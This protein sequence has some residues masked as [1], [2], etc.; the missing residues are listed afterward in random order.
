M[1]GTRISRLKTLLEADPTD[2]FTQYALGLEYAGIGEVETAIRLLE[3]LRQQ[4]PAYVPAYH[5]LGILYER[6]G[7]PD[8]ADTILAEGISVARTA[9]D[10]H[11]ANEMQEARDLLS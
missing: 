11:A 8:R 7:D 3:S 2:A 5:Q 4:H 9:G 1:S 6:H 10:E